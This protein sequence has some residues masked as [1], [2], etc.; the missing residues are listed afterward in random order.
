MPIVTERAGGRKNW[1][2][3]THK[4]IRRRVRDA[5]KKGE[6]DLLYDEW[7]GK[8]LPFDFFYLDLDVYFHKSRLGDE[9]TPESQ[10]KKM[11]SK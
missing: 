2:R 5:I 9:D 11:I 8:E 10:I 1:K 7:V 4:A 6:Y 3:L